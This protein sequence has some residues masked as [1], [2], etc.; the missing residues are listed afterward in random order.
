[1]RETALSLAPAVAIGEREELARSRSDGRAL[2]HQQKV[3]TH[4]GTEENQE[5]AVWVLEMG[6][7]N[8]MTGSQTAFQDFDT[9]VYGTMIFRDDSEA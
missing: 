7:T 1:V 4:L 2:L 9:T 3:F 8:H 6:A 5:V